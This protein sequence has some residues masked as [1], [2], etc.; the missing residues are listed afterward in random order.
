MGQFGKKNANKYD[1]QKNE[2]PHSFDGLCVGVSDPTSRTQSEVRDVKIY[3]FPWGIWVFAFLIL[4][5]DIW[6]L[7]EIVKG[8]L[9]EILHGEKKTYWWQYLLAL[10]ILIL[11]MCTFFNGRVECVEL[12]KEKGMMQVERKLLWPLN[13]LY[14]SKPIVYPLNMIVSVGIV[15]LGRSKRAEDNRH[16]KVDIKFNDGVR[17]HVLGSGDR[18]TVRKRAT[19][20]RSFLSSCGMSDDDNSLTSSDEF[21]SSIE[22]SSDLHNAT[23]NGIGA[24]MEH[25][26]PSSST[27]PVE[28]T[29]SEDLCSFLTQSPTNKREIT[30]STSSSELPPHKIGEDLVQLMT[31]SNEI[32]LYDDPVDLSHPHDGKPPQKVVVE[33]PTR[34]SGNEPVEAFHYSPGGDS[35]GNRTPLSRDL[36]SL[37]IDQDT[38]TSGT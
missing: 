29:Q 25:G 34:K 3:N 23:P 20:I 33:T 24:D 2:G 37:K 6:L 21:D 10:G 19:K 7:S 9:G 22:L 35:F 1:V 8:N 15:A 12:Y 17:L 30:E 11:A 36:F 18:K 32:S 27:N 16:W 28:W 4:L 5:V 26:Y 14:P 13:M 31:P 38:K